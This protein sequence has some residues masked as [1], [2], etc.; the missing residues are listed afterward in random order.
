LPCTPT[1]TSKFWWLVYDINWDEEAFIS[2]FEWGLQ[3]D[4][5]DLLLSLF[6]LQILNEALSQVV[7]CS[8]QLLKLWQDK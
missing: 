6:D 1:C 8:N 5:K 7:K 4:L 2:Q 3:D